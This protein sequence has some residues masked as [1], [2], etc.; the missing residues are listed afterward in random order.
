MLQFKNYSTLLFAGERNRSLSTDIRAMCFGTVTDASRT[1]QA[2][3]GQLLR[4]QVALQ[5]AIGSLRNL[6]QHALQLS[7]ALTSIHH[8]NFFHNVALTEPRS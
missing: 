2:T 3:D 1:L 7:H 6:N 5:T 8:D 4:S